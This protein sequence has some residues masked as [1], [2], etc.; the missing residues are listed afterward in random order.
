[1][2]EL[3]I[4]IGFSAG[5]TE[6][7]INVISPLILGLRSNRRPPPKNNEFLNWFRRL[8]SNVSANRVDV[9]SSKV[10]LGKLNHQKGVHTATQFPD[11]FWLTIPCG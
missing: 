4:T 2:F 10:V 7:I 11:T 5:R 1:M 9:V 3:L 8:K 6:Y